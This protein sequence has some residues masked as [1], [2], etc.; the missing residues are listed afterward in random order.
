MVPHAYAD[1]ATNDN[2]MAG[3]EVWEISLM[4]LQYNSHRSITSWAVFRWQWQMKIH[5]GRKVH[6]LSPIV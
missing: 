3:G 6:Q 2:I 5:S 1:E 4:H